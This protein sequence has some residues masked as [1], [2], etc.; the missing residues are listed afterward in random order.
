MMA[1]S[2]NQGVWHEWNRSVLLLDKKY[3]V[4]KT[5]KKYFPWLFFMMWN[6]LSL[7]GL[8]SLWATI[9]S[10]TWWCQLLN[11]E[12]FSKTFKIFFFYEMFYCNF[13]ALNVLKHPF[14]FVNYN[15]VLKFS[16]KICHPWY[17]VFLFTVR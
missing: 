10:V 8:V 1:C 5:I 9:H 13:V 11:V 6:W 3:L 4:Y 2:F 15:L 12:M 7:R 17:Y 14:F 16:A